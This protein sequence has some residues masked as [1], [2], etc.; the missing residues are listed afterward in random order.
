[1]IKGLL[2]LVAASMLTFV[3][4]QGHFKYKWFESNEFLT[5]LLGV[6]ISALYLWSVKNLVAAFNGE[7]WPS[8]LLSFAVG[9]II[10]AVMTKL[11][12]DEDFNTKTVTCLSLS[13]I[14][15]LIQLFW[16]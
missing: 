5:I 6:P 2:Q 13:F 9:A 16:K 10:F 1:M 12:F 14:I 11:W 4:L 15:V 3:Q 7:M 8:R